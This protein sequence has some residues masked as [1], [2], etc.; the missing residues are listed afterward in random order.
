MK[1]ILDLDNIDEK[2]KRKMTA[3]ERGSLGARTRWAKYHQRPI[4]KDA[5]YYRNYR[6]QKKL[7]PTRLSGLE[8]RVTRIE[9]TTSNN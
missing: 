1:K 9:R 3:H 7:K 2:R 6:Q 4:V 8:L 5:E